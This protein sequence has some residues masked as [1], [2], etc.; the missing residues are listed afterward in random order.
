MKRFHLRI[1]LPTILSMLLF[2][3]TIFL[4]LIPR[5]QQNIMDGKREMIMELTN[6]A[7][8]ILSKYETDEREGILDRE[9]AQQTAISRIQYLRYGDENKDYFWITD[10]HPT[11]VVH[12]FRNDLNGQDLSNLTDPHGKKLFVEF[13]EVVK[14]SQEGYVD[15]MWQWK[16]DSL[17]IVP[18]LSYV[19]IFK[20]WGWVIGTGVYIED[21]KKEISALT[22]SMVRISIGISIALAAL[23]FY[24][25]NQSITSER[26]RIEAETELH[27]SR[28][29]FRT[30]VE[31]ATEGLLM[32]NDGKISFSNSVISK[33]TGYSSDELTRLSLRQLISKTNNT[34]LIDAFSEETVKEGKYELNLA[35]K[36]GGLLE[37]LVTSSKTEFYGKTVNIIIV[38]DI[39]VEGNNSIPSV[40]YQKLISTLEIGF[41]KA[42]IHS[43]GN[44][45]YA[46][47]TAIR[48][49]GYDT[50]EELASVPVLGL[51]SDPEERINIRN[52]L[53]EHGFL[54]NK[55]LRIHTQKG[56][57]LFVSVSMVVVHKE[58]HDDLIC[59]GIMEDIT[60]QENQ[61]TRY[62]H[63]I[64]GLQAQHLI[65]HRQV[66]EFVRPVGAIDA[67]STISDVLR[68]LSKS[69]AGCLL[70][71]KNGK[72]LLGILTNTDVQK[73]IYELELSLDNP[74]YLIMSSPVQ[75]IAET[76]HVVDALRLSGS[77]N[78]HHLVV[79]NSARE[80]VGILRIDDIY[81]EAIGSG[82]PFDAEIWKAETPDDLQKSYLNFRHFIHPLVKSEVSA[83]IITR[84][85]TSFSDALIHQI[86]KM[87]IDQV[88]PPPVDFSFI[89]LGSEGREE[90]TLLTD[91]DNAL[92]YEDVL[93]VN[94]KEVKAYFNTLGEIICNHL[95]HAGYSFCPGNIMAKN[96]KWCGPLSLWEHYFTSWM[97]LPEQQ[98]LLDASIFFDFRKVYGPDVF[99]EK[100]HQR[101]AANTREYP[102]FLYHLANNTVQTKAEHLP[103]GILAE[104]SAD[105]VDLKNALIPI[106]MFARTYALQN[107]IRCSNTIDRLTALKTQRLVSEATIDDIVY[108]YNFLM[109]LRFRNQV[110]LSEKNLPL[111]NQLHYKTLPE[112]EIYLLKKVLSSI[113]DYQNKIKSDFK[114]T[115]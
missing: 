81:S 90:E 112:Q 114:I 44:F 105:S 19:K 58:N 48:M 2:I 29:K 12:P 76:M 110:S 43:K 71:T 83:K 33:M 54:K 115:I 85:T 13:V 67:D 107:D 26:K 59:D 4:I 51:L 30:L 73:R 39:S 80:I 79:R 28:E 101:I 102:L 66:S 94:E 64:A 74:A 10:L 25:S 35:R 65:W 61:R 104:K 32:V 103:A 49:L 93:P 70:L 72:D 31:A 7:L 6:A 5:Y 88:G 55:I 37:V 68:K 50:F 77:K 111:T 106:T 60:N 34:D 18:K 9:E 17:H 3:L 99:T 96:P 46:N 21:V 14:K 100:L 75:Y 84:I 108:S 63:L 36:N 56:A 38:K 97:A 8:S 62:E 23:L 11:M 20:P 1:F 98:Q 78:I 45:I 87:A 24:L 15:Y 47:Q 52:Q 40:E 69:N 41:F 109:K 53:L 82:Y 57:A 92:I 86:I 22:A 27:K 42:A 16:D 113:R 89:C 95:N 91:Q